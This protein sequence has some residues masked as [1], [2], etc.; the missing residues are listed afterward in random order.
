VT[1]VAPT[2]GPTAGGTAV[3]ITGTDFVSG[4][5][6]TFGGTA[7][8]GVTVVNATTITATTPVHAA[9]AVDV[10][11][12]NPDTKSGT[13][14]DGYTYVAPPTVT[15][16][17]PVSGLDTGGTAV[18]ITGT[19]FVSGATVTFGGTAAT[20]VTFVNSTSITATTPA[21]AAGAVDVVVTNPD[22]QSGTLTGETLT[23]NGAATNTVTVINVGGGTDQLYLAAVAIY[24]T[25]MAV[26]PPIDGG[27]LTWSL[28]KRQC[29]DRIA[30]PSVEIWQAFGSPG[31]P[32]TVTVNLDGTAD[33]VSAA[34]SRY[35]GADPTTPTEGADGSNT[36][37]QGAS[38]LCDLTGTDTDP[39]TLTLTSSNN[40]SVVY[41]ASHPRNTTLDTPDPAYTQR[42]FILNSSGGDGANLYVHD[43][44][45]ATAGP[46]T[47]THNIGSIRPWDMAGLVINPSGSGATWPTAEDTALTGLAKTTT[48]RLRIEISNAGTASGSV[49]YRLEVSDPNPASCDA[50]TYTRVDSS[51]HWNMVTSTH[52]ADGDPTSNIA[53]GLTDAPSKTFAAGQLKE[54]TDQTSG[55][56]LSGTEFTEIEY[57][58]QATASATDGATYCFRLTDAGTAT[59]FTYTEAKYGKVTLVWDGGHHYGYRLRQ[60]R[61]CHLRRHRRHRR[62]LCKLDVDH[63]HHGS[64]RRGRRRRRRH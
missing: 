16:V 45:L 12:T 57:A 33:R 9:G 60:R 47:I 63:G 21:H 17:A 1:N 18:T 32:F 31:A 2:S 14:I 22:T 58:V 29:A 5:T 28:Q 43:R 64:P 7:A 50:A 8:T 27:G 61:Y 38:A 23:G 20:G 13:F 3:T 42:A 26:S 48:K 11:V 35:S 59:S 25:N 51:T 55:I 54:S 30:Q 6:V 62:H 36:A 24:G 19:N 39:M 15:S 49:L 56:T 37:G 52:F 40:N 53:S 4:A 10:T 44:T 34:V 46:D 41:V